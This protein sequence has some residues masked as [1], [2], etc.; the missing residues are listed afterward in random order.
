MKSISW[1]CKD[2]ESIGGDIASL[3]SVIVS[4]QSEIV[5]LKETVKSNPSNSVNFCEQAWE[6]LLLEFEERDERKSNITMY[7]LPKQP[8]GIAKENDEV[9]T[10]IESINP[11]VR[12][13]GVRMQRLYK[14]TATSNKPRPIKI[15]FSDNHETRQLQL[16]PLFVLVLY[17]PPT[18]DTATYGL[19]FDAPSSLDIILDKQWLIVEDFNV[20]SY[21]EH[22]I[23]ARDISYSMFS[24]TLALMQYNEIR[25]KNKRILD[26]PFSNGNCRMRLMLRCH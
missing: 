10:I 25:N 4:L 7:G 24:E 15:I 26:F 16:S 8:S 2:C 20:P 5:A 1:S 19:F 13:D 17:A 14:F 12:S 21:V 11:D 18:T 23:D 22:L 3:K 9:N 6:E